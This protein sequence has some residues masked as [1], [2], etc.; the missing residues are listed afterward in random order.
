MRILENAINNPTK[1][2]DPKKKDVPT[3]A[4]SALA[5]DLLNNGESFCECSSQATAASPVCTDFIHFKTLLYE[6]IDGC[7]ALDAIDCDAWAEY[8]PPCKANLVDKYKKVDFSSKKQCEYARDRCGNVG[9]FPSF[10]RLDCGEEINGDAWDFYL[11]YERNCLRDGAPPKPKP[12][13]DPPKPTPAAP[14]KTNPPIAPTPTPPSPTPPTPAKPYSPGDNN[15]PTNK[16]YVPPE[17]RNRSRGHKFRN[18]ILFCGVGG[19]AYWYFS[20]RYGGFDY[21]QFRRTRNYEADSAGMYDSLTMQNAQAAFEPP[22][23]PPPPSSLG[24][25]YTNPNYNMGGV[26]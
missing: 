10:R 21:N 23:L 4:I 15:K 24:D 19:I 22:T 11:D 5:N 1:G 18:F 8:Y 17:E 9:P 12:I 25:G 26:A 13:P 2:V 7:K 20:K 6:S 3:A 14:K 16:K